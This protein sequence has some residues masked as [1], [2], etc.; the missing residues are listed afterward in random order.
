MAELIFIT[1]GTRSGKSGYAQRLAEARPGPLL[2]VATAGAGDAEMAERIARHRAARAERWKT[3][4]EPLALP[5]RLPA[6]AAGKGAVLIDCL[7]L[8]LSNLYFHHREE[9]APVLDAV[10]ALVEALPRIAPPVYLVS[11][12]LGSGVVPENRLARHFRDLAGEANQLL[13]AAAGEAWLVVAGLP[14]R[15]K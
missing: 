1:G 12:E 13:A 6:A 3:L 15:L 14:L 2:Y 4:E 11:N 5:K 7:T 9:P 8:W 10:A